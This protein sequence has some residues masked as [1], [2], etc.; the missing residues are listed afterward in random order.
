MKGHGLLDGKVVV[1]TAAAGTGIGGAAARRCLEEGAQVAISDQHHRRLAAARD[2]LAAGHG[3]R[4]WSQPCDV[5]DE[6]QI[7]ALIEGAAGHFGRIDVMINN[8]GLGGT[9]SVLDMTDEQWSRVL[10]VTLTGTSFGIKRSRVT[11]GGA[12]AKITSWTDTEIHFLVPPAALPGLRLVVV[13]N[14][15]GASVEPAT[16]T[17]Q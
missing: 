10:D 9:A 12:R 4:V 14:R 1:I 8:A 15:A 11:V 5:T 17:V 2:E 6:A 16:I 3:D 7:A 13:G